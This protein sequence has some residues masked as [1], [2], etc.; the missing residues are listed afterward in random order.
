M[1]LWYPVIFILDHY[2]D[3]H[4][5]S[6]LTKTT[7]NFFKKL[8]RIKSEMGDKY[9]GSVEFHMSHLPILLWDPNSIA[10]F[11]ITYLNNLILL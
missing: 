11:L 2:W 10:T 1:N 9:D 8:K 7:K 5:S 4:K 6:E 3:F